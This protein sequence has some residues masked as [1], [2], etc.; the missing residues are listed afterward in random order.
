MKRV[1]MTSV[2]VALLAPCGALADTIEFLSGA[3][4][5]GEVKEIRKSEREFDFEAS[6]GSRTVV[7][8][9]PFDKVHA[10]TMKGNRFTITPMPEATSGGTDAEGN[11]VR[12]SRQI[13]DLVKTVGSTMPD[14]YDSVE[15]DYPDSLDLSWPI[16]PPDKGWNNQKNMGQYIWDVINPN[17]ARWR[18]GIKLVHHCM[19]LHQGDSALLKRDMQVAGRMYFDLLQ[20]YPRAACWLRKA[21]VDKGQPGGVMLAECYWRMGNRQMAMQHL[22]ARSYAGAPPAAA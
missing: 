9:Y 21:G 12:T 4:I 14:W 20:D 17:P 19:T 11:V 6:L 3:K 18:S 5:S 22:V 10:V 16:K 2:V 13:D 1:W 8:T 15:L 7:R